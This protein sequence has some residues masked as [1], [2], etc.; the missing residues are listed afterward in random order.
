MNKIYK[1]LSKQTIKM[2]KINKKMKK[3]N[4]YQIKWIKIYKIE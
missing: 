3:S 4:N 1:N 2:K